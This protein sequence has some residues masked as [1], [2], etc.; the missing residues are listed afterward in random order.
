MLQAVSQFSSALESGQLGPVVSQL[1]V[2][3][4]AVAAATQGNMQEFVK[5]L[6]KNNSEGGSST[7]KKDES[8]KKDAKGKDKKGDDDEDMQID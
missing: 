3:P 4:E 8:E 5:A 7:K 2:N 1:A 6:E